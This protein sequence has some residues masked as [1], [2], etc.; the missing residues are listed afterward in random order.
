MIYTGTSTFLCKVPCLFPAVMLTS[1]CNV[2]FFFFSF[3]LDKCIQIWLQIDLIWSLGLSA[4]YN[5]YK[6]QMGRRIQ[7]VLPYQ[8]CTENFGK[9]MEFLNEQ[10]KHLAW[11]KWNKLL[12]DKTASSAVC[13][14]RV[15]REK[16]KKSLT[17]ITW[18]GTERNWTEYR[19][20][21]LVSI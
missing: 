13:V 18:K 14:S 9:H 6:Q 11:Q 16:K 3:F 7:I 12:W 4:N 21:D 10:W 17:K 1:Y 20:L 5:V 19:A 8:P 2:E 15:E